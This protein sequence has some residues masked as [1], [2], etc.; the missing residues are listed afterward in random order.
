MKI[1]VIGATGM[2]GK[3][4]VAEA[5]NHDLVVIAHA[6]SNDKLTALKNEFQSIETLAKDAFLLTESDFEAADVVIDAFSTTPDKAYLQID[7]ATKLVALLRES[8]TRLAF[9]LG[10]G[11]LL[12]AGDGNSNEHLAVADIEKDDSTLP[13]RA[14]PKNQ[15]KELNFLR[16][17]D[18]VDWFGISPGL[19][20]VAGEK[21]Q[22]ILTGTDHLLINDQGVSETTAGTM[23]FALVAEILKPTHHNARFT[24]A[25]A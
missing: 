20:F 16:D 19:N 3:A 8:K 2:T 12:V 18:N 11:S 22:E 6:R 10:A 21:S 25:N 9:V 15:L 13:W 14:I 7:L 4:I 5:L 17:V 24:V 23:A 1:F